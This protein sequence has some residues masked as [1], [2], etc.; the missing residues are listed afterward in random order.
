MTMYYFYTKNAWSSASD[1]NLLSNLWMDE[2]RTQQ[3][4]VL[5]GSGDQI[6]LQTIARFGTTNAGLVI[7]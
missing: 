6:T 4:T 2:Q 7:V 3:A 1:I 5:P